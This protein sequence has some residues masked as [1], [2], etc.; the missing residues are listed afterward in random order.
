[1]VVRYRTDNE[2]LD[3]LD[4]WELIDNRLIIIRDNKIDAE[5][6]KFSIERL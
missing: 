5:I 1:M 3:V 6:K 2:P 4:G